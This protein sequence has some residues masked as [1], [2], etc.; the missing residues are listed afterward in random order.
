ML[1]IALHLGLNILGIYSEYTILWEEDMILNIFFNS[2][3]AIFLK[4]STLSSLN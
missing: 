2:S 4:N 3:N 1:H